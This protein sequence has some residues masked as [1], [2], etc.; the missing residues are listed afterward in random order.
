[1][2]IR[3]RVV[4]RFRVL[5]REEPRHCT[6]IEWSSISQSKPST[7]VTQENPGLTFLQ[8]PWNGIHNVGGTVLILSDC[9]LDD[10][11][12]SR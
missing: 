4:R 11:K 10:I 7:A 1:M 6:A 2:G 8:V 5:R 12:R 3:T 9:S